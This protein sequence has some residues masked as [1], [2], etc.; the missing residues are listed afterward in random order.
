MDWINIERV[1]PAKLLRL[2][3]NDKLNCQDHIDLISKKVGQRMYFLCLSIMLV[4]L[5][6]LGVYAS[7][8][9]SVLKDACEV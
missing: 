2:M 8:L 1:T 9:R 4:N 3:I 6:D 7:M 5:N